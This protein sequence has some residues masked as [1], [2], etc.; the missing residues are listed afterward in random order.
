MPDTQCELCLAYK[1]EM[2]TKQPVICETCL[3]KLASYD[4]TA[5]ERGD[6]MRAIKEALPA[7]RLLRDLPHSFGYRHTISKVI[8]GLETTYNS[9][10]RRKGART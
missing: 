9:C 3:D 10:L 8:G 1:N 4:I 5:L 2:D 6:L 7:L